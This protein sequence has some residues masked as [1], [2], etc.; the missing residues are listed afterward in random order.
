VAQ[1][2]RVVVVFQKGLK[3]L[4]KSSIVGEVP[5]HLKFCS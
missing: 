1:V 5:N 3:D 2:N 4:A